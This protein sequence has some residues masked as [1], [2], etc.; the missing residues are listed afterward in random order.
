MDSPPSTQTRN[1]SFERMEN[2]KKHHLAVGISAL[3]GTNAPARSRTIVST[4]IGI[5]RIAHSDS[6]RVV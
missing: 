1:F 4:R 2:A 6:N 5:A 3:A